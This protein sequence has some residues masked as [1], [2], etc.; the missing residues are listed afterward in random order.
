MTVVWNDL[1]CAKWD[2]KPYSAYCIVLTV[3]TQPVSG[4]YCSNLFDVYLKPYFL[5]AYRPLHKGDIFLVRGGM[6]A[7]EFKVIETDPS[8]YCIVAPDTVIHCEGEP[9]KREVRL[10]WFVAVLLFV[11]DCKFFHKVSWWFSCHHHVERIARICNQR[12]CVLQQMRKQGLND[13][14]FMQ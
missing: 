4:W 6:R 7:V 9:V 10:C 5:E 8:P 3:L 14:C 2:I 1:L 12:F 13:D 11:L